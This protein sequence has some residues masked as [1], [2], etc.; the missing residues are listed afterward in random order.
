VV[1]RFGGYVAEG[2]GDG[3]VCFFGLPGAHEDDAERAVR[4]ALAIVEAVRTSPSLPVRVGIHTGP[5]VVSQRPS[6]TADVLGEAPDVAARVEPI[7]DPGSVL[8]TGATQRLVA[9]QFLVDGPRKADL[10]GGHGPLLLYRVHEPSGV[11]GWLARTAANVLTPFVGREQ[12]RRLLL[13]RWSRVQEGEGQVV[14]ILGEPGIGKSRLVQQFKADLTG[15]PHTWIE[16]AASPH[17]ADSPL[18]LLRESVLKQAFAWDSDTSTQ[19]R[20]DTLATAVEAAGFEAAKAVPLLAS[21]LDLPLPV[22]RYPPLLLSPEQQ[23]QRLLAMLVQWI[24]ALAR[25]Q[26]HIVVTEDVHWADPSTLEVFGLLA[27]QCATARILLIQTARPGFRPPWPL[28]GNHTRLTLSRLTDTQVRQMIANVPARLKAPRDVVETL[29]ARTDGVPLFVEEL[30]RAVMERAEEGVAPS[31]VPA[32]LQSGLMARLDR[33]GPAKQV[34]QMASVIGREFSYEVL[35]HVAGRQHLGSPGPEGLEAALGRLVDAELIHARGLPPGGTYIFKHALVQETAYESLLEHRR[36]ELH[37][38]IATLLTERFANTA[39]AEPGVLARH[40]EAAGEAELA[41]AAWQEAAHR[42][43]ERH[44]LV[45]AEHHFTRAIRAVGMLPDTPSRNRQ[46]LLIQLALGPI[47]GLSHGYS[48]PELSRCQARARDLSEQ[49]GDTR[50]L[51]LILALAFASAITRCE[52]RAALAIADQLLEV[53]ERDGSTFA[54]T[55]AHFLQ[56]LARFVVGDLV[57]ALGHAKR[58]LT[59]YREEDHRGWPSDLGVL[60][61]GH[62]AFVFAAQ[63]LC[64]RA[65]AEVGSLLEMA[66]RLESPTHRA[67]AYEMAICAFGHL[68]DGE[69]ILEHADALLGL[70]RE[71]SVPMWLGHARVHRGWARAMGGHPAEGIAELREGIEG[72][73]ASQRVALGQYLGF[74]AEAQLVAGD[75]EQGLA[76]I[77]QALAAAPAERLHIPELLRLRGELLI[78]SSGSGPPNA[79]AP[80]ASVELGGTG[81]AE[82]ERCFAEAIA[83]AQEMGA[84]LVELRAVVSLARL[85]QRQGRS[86]EGLDLLQPVYASFTEGFDT[87][88]LREARALLQELV[89]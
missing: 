38:Q 7:A 57:P 68:R 89:R 71:H 17:H 49:L 86:K 8:I 67:E 1:R 85:R 58:A 19:A 72:Y 27:G 45:E 44:A 40:W 74:L 46:E 12:E 47:L 41:A 64:D 20:L 37:K 31:Q 3:L 26:P 5:V 28:R 81:L 32:T 48:S 55:Y 53:A 69:R 80:E 70:A 33:L 84:K 52:A 30:T 4:A 56:A 14:L 50:Q 16:A 65:S 63:G 25:A 54:F 66:P 21:V 73:V 6:G 13:E 11:R 34:A 43:R 9:G 61:R 87:R 83:L 29:V 62:L 15:A 78:A 22:G 76:T 2:L 82:A 59:F 10:G 35:D 88:G 18:Y 75:V 77:D 42:A 24:F 39:G 36:R 79:L 51:L 60:A 23:R